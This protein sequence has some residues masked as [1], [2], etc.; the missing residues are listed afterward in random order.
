MD[1]FSSSA[2]KG[3]EDF[4]ESWPYDFCVNMPGELVISIR[5][6]A[7]VHGLLYGLIQKA[8]Y[9]DHLRAMAYYLWC[10]HVLSVTP[11]SRRTFRHAYPSRVVLKDSHVIPNQHYLY[12]SCGIP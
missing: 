6:W 10:K 7:I 8:G 1:K 9:H 11:N 3:F 12:L 5:L 4:Q 2:I